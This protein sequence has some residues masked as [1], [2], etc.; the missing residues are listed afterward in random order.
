M[1]LVEVT[2][3]LPKAVPEEMEER[4]LITL[5]VERLASVGVTDPVRIVEPETA[6]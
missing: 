1:K 2:V 4:V 3:E 6:L 5:L